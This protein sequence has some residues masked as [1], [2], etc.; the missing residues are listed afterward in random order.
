M[1][2]FSCISFVFL[3]M[4]FIYMYVNYMPYSVDE[5]CVRTQSYWTPC[6][7]MDCRRLDLP[8]LHHLPEFAQTQV[9]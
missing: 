9:C 5:L 2:T 3:S 8:V 7:P 4:Y 6:D 1:L